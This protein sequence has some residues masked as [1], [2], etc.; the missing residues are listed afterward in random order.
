MA[1]MNGAA[2]GLLATIP[3]TALMEATWE[4]LPPKEQYPL[5]P[6]QITGEVGRAVGVWQHLP[7]PA[8]EA[9]TLLSHFS[10]GAAAGGLYEELVP[11]QARNAWT[12]AA[13]GLGI[14]TAS[15]LGLMP[16][17]GILRPATRHPPRR[18]ALMIAAHLVWGGVLGS[19]TRDPHA[20]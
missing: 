4:Q 5:P 2:A 13:Y 8:K 12:G 17:L 7:E 18:N 19:L 20:T 1:A 11:R 3:M 14:W 6:R 15:Y 9:T 10:Y 16:A